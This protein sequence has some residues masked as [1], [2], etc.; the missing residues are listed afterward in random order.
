MA[1][2]KSSHIEL[3]LEELKSVSLY[4]LSSKKPIALTRV[5][6][7]SGFTIGQSED[8]KLY[9]NGQ[10]RFCYAGS[11]GARHIV[12][13]LVALGVLTK[14]QR[15]RFAARVK[16]EEEA[17]I[18]S[19]S[20]SDFYSLASKLNITL[21]AQQ[22]KKLDALSALCSDETITNPVVA[23][24]EPVAAAP[25][26]TEVKNKVAVK[27]LRTKPKA[28][29]ATSIEIKPTAIKVTKGK[30]NKPDIKITAIKVTRVKKADAPVFVPA[31]KPSDPTFV[32]GKKPKKSSTPS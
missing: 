22:N 4:P 16:K 32:P 15:E 18:L 13:A 26:P 31:K 8:G 9:W 27:A 3:K 28:E 25:A 14:E 1:L 11:S 17:D 20:I 24:V 21:T 10:S 30:D 5:V 29:E 19:D 12:D 7:G 23:A 2:V 6:Q